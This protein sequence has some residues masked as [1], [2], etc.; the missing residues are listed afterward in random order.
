M[1]IIDLTN[2]KF[3][4]LT[5][6][7]LLPE[8]KHNKKV[9]KCLCECGNYTNVIGCDLTSGKTKSCG[10]YKKDETIKRN[11]THGMTHTR[12]YTTWQNMKKRCYNKNNH[13]YKDYG[14]RGISICDTW[15]HNLQAFYDWAMSNGYQDNLTIDRIDVNG[16]YEPNNCRWATPKQQA[17]NR[18]N[19]II[20]F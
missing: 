1:K 18:R 16:N 2:S 11:I 6:I 5:V 15:L 4:R 3:G 19:N 10:C 14:G 13:K 8:R 20:K 12:L 17:N 9:Y 7:K